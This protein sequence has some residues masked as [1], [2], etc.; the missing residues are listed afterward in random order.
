[1]F[2]QPIK[3]VAGKHKIEGIG[4]NF[5]PEVLSL[6]NVDEVATVSYE[7]AK[8]CALTLAKHEGVLVGK[9]SGAS[10]AVALKISSKEEYKGKVIVCICPDSG[11]RYL[12]TDLFE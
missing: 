7:E 6:N 9:S 1:M 3:S 8:E 11:E 2:L 12:T 4:A 10:L 5:I